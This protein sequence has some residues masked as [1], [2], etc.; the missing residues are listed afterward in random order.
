MMKRDNYPSPTSTLSSLPG[1]E[2]KYNVS[3]LQEDDGT[4]FKL[5]PSSYPINLESFIQLL[6]DTIRDCNQ[7]QR[8]NL[9]H[10][11]KNDPIGSLL[12]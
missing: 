1:E 11:G 3:S 8:P 10:D 12:R 2:K 5:T 7:S 6:P 9:F 4:N